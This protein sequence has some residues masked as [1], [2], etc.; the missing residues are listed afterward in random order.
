VCTHIVD[1]RNNHLTSVLIRNFRKRHAPVKTYPLYM[2]YL[3][4]KIPYSIWTRNWVGIFCYSKLDRV[5]IEIAPVN[6][7]WLFIYVVE[8]CEHAYLRYTFSLTAVGFCA[9]PLLI[10][11]TAIRLYSL[12]HSRCALKFLTYVTS[13][14][15]VNSRVSIKS[16]IASLWAKQINYLSN[17]YFKFI[18]IKFQS[19]QS[20]WNHPIRKGLLPAIK[21]VV[22]PITKFLC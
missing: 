9:L 2:L 17:K 15:N 21:H 10:L 3:C 8:A 16:L 13:L 12:F 11:D 6:P 18:Q 1:I 22:G 14:H 4:I 7:H 5:R 20:S 19:R